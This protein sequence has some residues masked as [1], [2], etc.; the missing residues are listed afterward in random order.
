MRMLIGRI[1][2]D[3]PGLLA[4]GDVE[5]IRNAN[6]PMRAFIE[7]VHRRHADGNEDELREMLANI[8]EFKNGGSIEVA[9]PALSA[10]TQRGIR[11]CCFSE[12]HANSKMWGHYASSHTGFCVQYRTLELDPPIQSGSGGAL[13]T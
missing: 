9:S 8:E 13:L 6:S 2:N 3:Y 10:I 7:A 12:T 11:A 4:P 1:Y 5:L